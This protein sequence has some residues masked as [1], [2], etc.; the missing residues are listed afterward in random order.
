MPFEKRAEPAVGFKHRPLQFEGPDPRS[1]VG[2]NRG[3]I[4]EYSNW[5]GVLDDYAWFLVCGSNLIEEDFAN[6]GRT[7]NVHAGL[8]PAVRGLDAFKWAILN[9]LPLG[10]T[11]HKIDSCTNSGEIMCHL[12]TPVFP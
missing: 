2:F 3:K 12:P 9:N 7:L 1:L 8:I 6:S 10:N 4:I 5:R 11:L